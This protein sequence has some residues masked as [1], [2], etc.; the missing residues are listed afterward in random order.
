M[1]RSEPNVTPV[2][3]SVAVH[4]GD[5]ASYASQDA[6]SAP[7]TYVP[8][9]IAAVQPL[10]SG[11]ELLERT[12]RLNSFPWSSSHAQFSCLAV[13]VA[14]ELVHS[15][16]TVARMTLYQH[17]SYDSIK[18]RVTPVSNRYFRGALA[19]TFW[20][21]PLLAANSMHPT[22]LSS[23]PTTIYD[24]SSCQAF[25]LDIPWTLPLS[26][27]KL[28]S[29]DGNFGFV[30]FWVLSPLVQDTAADITT[31][32]TF[33]LEATFVNPR[34]HD[35]VENSPLPGVINRPARFTASGT[36]V[37]LQMPRKRRTVQQEADAKAEKGTV[38]STLD[39]VAAIAD[40]ASVIPVIG[41]F[42][43]GL[44]VVASAAS[45][46]FD[47]FGMSKPTNITIPYHV[48][49]GNLPFSNCLSGVTSA[50]VFAAST[51]PYVSNEPHLVNSYTDELNLSTIRLTPSLIASGTITS[52][53]ENRLA[54]TIPVQPYYGWRDG[55]FYAPS[56][57]DFGT[58]A[59]EKWRG[60]ISYK[61]VFPSSALATCRLAITHSLTKLTTFTEQVRHTY[62]DV[63]GTT[64][65]DVTIPWLQPQ[66]Y[67]SSYAYFDNAVRAANG[68][69]QVWQILPLTGDGSAATPPPITFFVFA[70]AGNTF[71]TATLRPVSEAFMNQAPA[72]GLL[73]FEST[74]QIGNLVA[75]DNVQSF[76]ELVQRPVWV[77]QSWPIAGGRAT[78]DLKALLNTN[79][80][81]ALN[82]RYRFYRGSV[83]VSMRLPKS[84]EPNFLVMDSSRA[85]SYLW[86][87]ERS[88]EV[89]IILPYS[90]TQAFDDTGAVYPNTETRKIVVRPNNGVDVNFECWIAV[91]FTDDFA[92]GRS[93]G[94]SYLM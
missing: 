32:I 94:C 4:S 54:L 87:V 79:L 63:Q 21:G 90:T 31:S 93:L 49:T 2:D 7:S 10:L 62:V 3:T 85:C 47:W 33:N 34:L 82:N 61:I 64:V 70:S 17:L 86:T 43:S 42:A 35:P 18:L 80:M 51:T 29:V 65:A 25:E 23:I 12:R 89:T 40:A 8:T 74:T 71:S 24:A 27:I 56:N 57:I 30:I 91:H 13:P 76:R 53:D 14:N 75:D 72:Q 15:L 36:F 69:V 19:S 60:D 73:G 84:S 50:D 44:S 78:I 81:R 9:Q 28:S 5:I 67:I 68:Y 77:Y 45:T 41:T 20:P 88:P 22:R 92:M 38:S 48:N 83:V 26:K 11:S 66:P 58:R 59:F 39:S 52:T 6:L 55:T 46:V 16:S 37:G 1:P